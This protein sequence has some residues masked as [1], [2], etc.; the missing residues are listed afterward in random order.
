M[1]RRPLLVPQGL[2]GRL[3][4]VLRFRDR[5]DRLALQEPGQ[6]DQLAPPE[7]AALQDRLALQEQ[8][9]LQE[10]R[11]RVLLCQVQ[12][13]RPARLEPAARLARLAL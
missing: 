5:L 12:Q 11:A 9:G 13:V 7:M 10:P 6:R 1:R 2:R 3:A 8:Q 4:L